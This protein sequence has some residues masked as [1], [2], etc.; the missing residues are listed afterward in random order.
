M[1]LI[2][3]IDKDGLNRF[4]TVPLPLSLFS[5]SDGA[6]ATCPGVRQ[7]SKSVVGLGKG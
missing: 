2:H 1:K 7:V 6:T 3:V 4:S 5:R